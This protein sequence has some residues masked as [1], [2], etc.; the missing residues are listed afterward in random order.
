MHYCTEEKINYVEGHCFLKKKTQHTAA[1]STWTGKQPNEDHTVIINQDVSR[2]EVA[3]DDAHR[4]QVPQSNCDLL[5]VIPDH[6][7]G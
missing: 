3:M 1:S 6:I 2:N 4:M 7:M 5:G